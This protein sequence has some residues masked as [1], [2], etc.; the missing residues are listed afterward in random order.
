MLRIYLPGSFCETAMYVVLSTMY[1][2]VIEFFSK[3][4]KK[5]KK[6]FKRITRRC[7]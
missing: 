3:I 7:I 2:R 1:G 4:I 6:K 5:K